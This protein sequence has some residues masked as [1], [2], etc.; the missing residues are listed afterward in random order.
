M[1]KV[2]AINEFLRNAKKL[3]KKY[4]SL[5]SDLEE[6][7]E[8]LKENPTKGIQITEDVYKIRLAI[9]SKGKGK[10]GGARVITYV[11]VQIIEEETD[12]DVF[13][14]TIYDK[15]AQADVSDAFVDSLVDEVK[16]LI[17]EARPEEDTIEEEEESE[18]K[19]DDEE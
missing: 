15:S 5:D 9:K 12:T 19:D 11:Y 1:I 4:R 8:D 16:A 3:R 6:L 10:S 7:I 18:E 2:I 13:L 14:L 17:E